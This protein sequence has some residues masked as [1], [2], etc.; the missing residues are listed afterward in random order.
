MRIVSGTRALQ[1][2]I[3]TS[4]LDTSLQ[5]LQKSADNNC[6]GDVI[7][8]GPGNFSKILN[9]GKSHDELGEVEKP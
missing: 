3:K 4:R 2:S 8:N 7:A 6:R 5:N 9:S 1:S